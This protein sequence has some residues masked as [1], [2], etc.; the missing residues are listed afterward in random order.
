MKLITFAIIEVCGEFLYAFAVQFP[1][2]KHMKKNED[3]M[4]LKKYTKTLKKTDCEWTV[5]LS[6]LSH[7]MCLAGKAAFTALRTVSRWGWDQKCRFS[8]K[9]RYNAD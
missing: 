1:T 8:A 9:Q 6:Y 4:Q 5:G 2:K 3:S 7:I